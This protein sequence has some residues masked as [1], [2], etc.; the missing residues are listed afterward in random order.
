MLLDLGFAHE[1]GMDTGDGVTPDSPGALV[2]TLR[3]MSPE[4]ATRSRAITARSD[5]FAAGLLLYYA[6]AAEIPFRGRT[7][8]DVLVAIVRAAPI[9]LRRARRD[10]PRALEA[11]LERA[12]SKHPD[13][14]FGSA[15]EMRVALAAVRRACSPDP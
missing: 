1:P 9:P 8:L 2:G 12:L 14:R 3:F 6:L 10:T 5:L 15:A 7:D 13:A 4:Q 11:V